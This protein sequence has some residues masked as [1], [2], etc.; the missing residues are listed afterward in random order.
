M[1]DINVA[2]GSAAAAQ[3]YHDQQI[4]SSVWAEVVRIVAEVGEKRMVY[5][6]QS[7]RPAGYRACALEILDRIANVQASAVATRLR[8][9]RRARRQP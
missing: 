3:A 9:R 6:G 1:T 4:R 2:L 7:R 5:S 8:R